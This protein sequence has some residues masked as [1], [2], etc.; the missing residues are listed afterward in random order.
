MS[1]SLKIILGLLSVVLLSAGLGAYALVSLNQ[2]G[3]AAIEMYDK[4]LMAINFARASATNFAQ[5]RMLLAQIDRDGGATAAAEATTEA[6][7]AESPAGAAA[8]GRSLSERQRLLNVAAGK[9]PLAGPNSERQRLLATAAAGGSAETAVVTTNETPE[10]SLP[11]R[12]EAIEALSELAEEFLENIEVVEERALSEASRAI[13]AS[14]YAI[15]EEWVEANEAFLSGV[16]GA[17]VQGLAVLIEDQAR[18]DDLVEQTAA[19]GFEFRLATEESVESTKTWMI[20]AMALTLLVALAVAA[21]L[22]VLIVKPLSSAVR[23]LDALS[24][25]GSADS[26][27][28]CGGDEVGAITKAIDSFKLHLAQMRKLEADQEAMRAQS[29]RDRRLYIEQIAT[30][31]EEGVKHLL[32]DTLE[33]SKEMRG[34][35][36]HL[37]SGALVTS[38][39]SA[40]LS[41][42]SENAAGSVQSVAAASE[43]L[44]VSIGEI[45]QQVGQCTSTANVAVE[46][47]SKTNET[48]GGLADAAQNIGEVVDMISNI[49]EQTNLLA[50][51][52]TIEAA[53][54]GEAGKGFAVVA[55]EVKSLANQT[56]KA[57]HEISEQIGQMQTV[58]GDAVAAIRTIGQTITE[59]SEAAATIASTIEQQNAATREITGNVTRASDSVTDL[60]SNIEEVAAVADEVGQQANQV[61][62]VSVA[63]SDKIESIGQQITKFLTSVRSDSGERRKQGRRPVDVGAEIRTPDG[64]QP[65]RV[66]EISP[67]GM[68]VV[69]PM[70]LEVGQP[71]ALEVPGLGSV[72]GRVLR[73]DEEASVLCIAEAGLTEAQLDAFTQQAPGLAA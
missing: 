49:A 61:R 20:G 17:R 59:M 28:S 60:S 32:V 8:L 3:R 41:S 1:I 18:L 23:D 40:Q 44:S 27:P 52:A 50:L 62:N 70:A 15:S 22:M 65:C 67:R 42:T 72:T 48:V 68:R 56:A 33:A 51:N 54:A 66:V 71:V 38:E 31:F 5:M 12:A 6:T 4:P 19:E 47:V 53:R 36:D 16:E 25:A 69:A 39:K 10:A 21:I 73:L 45:D 58:T 63:M 46:Q 37:A 57:T 2:M 13:A 26:C 24:Q 34:A 11:D 55:G 35:A 64:Q 14:I 43:E 29:E 30:G 7:T 9:Q